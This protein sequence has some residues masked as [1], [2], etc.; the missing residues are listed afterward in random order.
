MIEGLGEYGELERPWAVGEDDWGIAILRTLLLADG[1]K[2]GELKGKDS[3]DLNQ[4]MMERRWR[5]KLAIFGHGGYGE[6]NYVLCAGDT[7]TASAYTPEVIDFSRSRTSDADLA[8]ALAILDIVP[9][10]RKAAW[11]VFP[12][13][14]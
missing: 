10:Q 4:L 5:L 11:L 3:F 8:W 12:S 9:V 2:E 13:Y 6:D 1:M 7:Q 14:G